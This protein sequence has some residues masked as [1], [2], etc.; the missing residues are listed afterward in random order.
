MRH[1]AR[2][3]L[4]VAVFFGLEK[5]L[6]FARHFLVARQF[7]L[8]PELDAYNAANN[9]PDLLFMLISGGALAMAFIPVLTET[10]QKQGLQAS[11]RV[12]S[13]VLNLLFLVT[14]SLSLLIALFAEQLVRSQIGIVPGFSADQQR[15][16]VDLMRLNLIGTLLLSLGGL[17]VAGLQSN[18]H[19]WLPAIALSLYDLGGLIGVV[20]LAPQEGYR[21][22]GSSLPA[23][24]WGVYGLVSGTILGAL[25][26]LCVQI[27]GLLRYRFRWNWGLGLQNPMVLK[28][29]NLMAPRVLT[30]LFI[31][32]TFVAQ[33]NLAS[34]LAAGSIT[35]LAYGWLFFQVPETLIGTA[36]GTVLLPT[37]AEQAVA[38][39]RR[40]FSRTL[41]TTLRVVLAIAVP[42]TALLIV[43]VRPA[44]AL[45]NFG[46]EGEN[47]VVW[48]ARAYFLGLLGHSLQEVAVRAFYA[49]QDARTPL[50]S[51]ALTSLAF[52]LLGV[53][54][55]RPL[56]AGG[57]AL[58]NALAFS[59]Q[60]LV[61]WELLRRTERAEWLIGD[62]LKRAGIAAL[63]CAA[64][65]WAI[66]SSGQATFPVAILA[67]SAG[68]SF[69]AALA[70][71]EIRILL[72]L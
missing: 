30:V 62:T 46:E 49:R 60:A 12:F 5:V 10:R 36:L 44:V 32:L 27:P 55:Y 47:L 40:A 18:Q 20:F 35:A 66:F 64:I 14:A 34:R 26:Y 71:P 57:I 31:Q 15:V 54:L 28:S 67:G 58:A 37:L 23:M 11:W 72:R 41:A 39:D 6:G 4:I 9:L 68:L 21:I 19:F 65:P 56:G 29:L 59:A 22:L 25:L 7:G 33:D 16:V 50:V 63:L 42:L 61:L 52:V 24:G 13:S 45:F 3:T 8:S 17:A 2:S 48:T 70:L 38:Q 43:V 1:I 51:A 69:L 53:L